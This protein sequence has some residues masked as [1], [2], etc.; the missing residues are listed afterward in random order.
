MAKL[1]VLEFNMH[2]TFEHYGNI[3]AYM[4]LTGLV[5]PSSTAAQQAR[6]AAA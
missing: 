2:Y 5:P 6:G 4:R 3:A 1:S